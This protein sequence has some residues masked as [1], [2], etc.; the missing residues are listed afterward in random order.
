MYTTDMARGMLIAHVVWLFHVVVF[1]PANFIMA[2]GGE[3]NVL[4]RAVVL[5]LFPHRGPLNRP[6]SQQ[7]FWHEVL[8]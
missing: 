3:N 6:F 1:P 7:P 4:L 2:G 8:G 5:K